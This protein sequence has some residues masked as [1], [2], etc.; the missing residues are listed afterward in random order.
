MPDR[1]AGL[2]WFMFVVSAVV[3]VAVTV[4][5]VVAILPRRRERRTGPD[6]TPRWSVRLV[7]GGGVVFPL[8]VLSFLWVLTLRDMAA[9]SE[10]TGPTSLTVR[11]IGYQWWWEVRYPD[12]GNFAVANEVHIPAGRP[13]RVLL[14]T[15]DV[16]HSF[17][18]PQVMGKMDLISGKVNE[19][20]MEAN[21]PGVYR[22]QCAEY[23]G[24]QH[25]NMALYVVA[26]APGDFQTWLA[27]ERR[28]AAGPPSSEASVGRQVFLNAP[29]VAC[30]TIRGVSQATAIGQVFTFGQNQPFTAVL[31]PDLTH[32]G[33]RL[34][35]G[36][37]TVP[38]TRGNLGGWIADSQTIK[39]G[40]RM[41]PIQLSGRD[42]Q[43]L[44]AY[45]E[46]LD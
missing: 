6:D 26:H 43:A 12:F 35:I 3:V 44:I 23:C 41:P 21:T 36:A 29:C 17:W 34:S 13:V 33:S 16:I 11:V 5:I 45:L 24:G 20:W 42:L 38:N 8:I 46:S 14:E 37:G 39:P 27:S 31:G 19:T 9:N 15:R 10:P 2:F 1:V 7:V 40:N 30:H 32:F 28:D 4:L 25:A 18:V 22:G